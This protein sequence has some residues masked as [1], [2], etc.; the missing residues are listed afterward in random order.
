MACAIRQSAVT[1]RCLCFGGS[2]QHLLTRLSVLQHFGRVDPVEVKRLALHD[3]PYEAI[4]VVATS[5]LAREDGQARTCFPG[6]AYLTSTRSP[7]KGGDD[8]PISS[9]LTLMAC[10]RSLSARRCLARPRSSSHL[11]PD[12]A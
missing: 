12:T 3:M 4:M 5:I 1:D 10:T 2:H 11:A 9:A 6:P 8:T 7:T